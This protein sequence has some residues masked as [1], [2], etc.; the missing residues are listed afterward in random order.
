MMFNGSG[1]GDPRSTIA[2]A[3]V[4]AGLI[5]IASLTMFGVG[6]PAVASSQHAEV[7]RWPF[8]VAAIASLWCASGTM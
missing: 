4:L 3:I 5:N 8:S 2:D 6:A 1:H 7:R